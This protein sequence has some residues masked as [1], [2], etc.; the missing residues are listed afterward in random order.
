[1]LVVGLLGVMVLVP[2]TTTLLTD[3][4][5]EKHA[6]HPVQ[7]TDLP[8]GVE[9]PAACK[10]AHDDVI[11]WNAVK[12]FTCHIFLNLILTPT[13]SRWSDYYGRKPFLLYGSIT[14]IFPTFMVFAYAK[15]GLPLWW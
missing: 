1:M 8:A 4:F 15:F 10:D 9:P 7:C 12:S 5:S 11:Q 6:G 14:A 3:Y 13:L 2:Y